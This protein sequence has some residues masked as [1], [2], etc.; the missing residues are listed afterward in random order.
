MVSENG[1]YFESLSKTRVSQGG[2][3]QTKFQRL[4]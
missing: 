2:E 1:T 4:Q 3:N